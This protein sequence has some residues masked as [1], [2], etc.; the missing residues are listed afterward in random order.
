MNFML[1]MVNFHL[2]SDDDLDCTPVYRLLQIIW[3]PAQVP[4]RA[5][6]LLRCEHKSLFMFRTNW[7]RQYCVNLHML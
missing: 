2:K 5:L 1:Q 3:I 6:I 7:H 4:T